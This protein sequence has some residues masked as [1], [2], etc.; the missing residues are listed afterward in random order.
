MSGGVKVLLQH[1]R[2]LGE[3]GHDA[4]LMTNKIV[5]KWADM[6]DNT[7]ILPKNLAGMPDCDLYVATV[8]SEVSTLYQSKGP[9]VAHLCQGYEP[10]EYGA[11]IRGES[12][13][14]RYQAAGPFSF[15]KR[16]GYNLRFR[17]KIRRFE[18]VYALPTIKMAVSRHLVSLIKKKYGKS[19]FLVQNGVDHRVFHPGSRP[20]VEG[21][22]PGKVRVLST[23]SMHV[24]FKGIPDALEAIKILKRRGCPVEL[25]RVS[26]G[27]PSREEAGSGVVDRFLTAI[28]EQE[29][30]ALYRETDIFVSSSLE[31]EGFG[32][33][34]IE[35]LS[36][37]VPSVLTE[38]STYLNFS[39]GR[40]FAYFVPIHRPEAIADGITTLINDGAIRKRCIERGFE[41]A[42]AFSLERT[43]EHLAAFVQEISARSAR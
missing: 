9:K 30:A 43:K 39:S 35:A 2:L 23:G 3:L 18:A 4:L 36:S 41:V 29:M 38:I 6:P 27:P 15:L 19:C 37:G 12:V 16:A 22:L 14:E 11:R 28:S 32:L 20:A 21:A 17:R 40:D 25:T 5:Y 33:P 42:R 31:G 1:V 34:A 7:I 8:A 13:T 24:G 10:E 26:P